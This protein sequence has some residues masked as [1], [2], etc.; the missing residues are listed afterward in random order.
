[1][2]VCWDC[3]AAFCFLFTK[4][5]SNPLCSGDSRMAAEHSLG[6]AAPALLLETDWFL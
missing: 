4:E 5:Q 6:S 1:M 2:C 3:L